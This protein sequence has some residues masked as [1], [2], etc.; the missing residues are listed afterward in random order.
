MYLQYICICIYLH[1]VFVSF[2]LCLSQLISSDERPDELTGRKQMCNL[3][4]IN[5]SICLMLSLSVW[6]THFAHSHCIVSRRFVKHSLSVVV[7]IENSLTALSQDKHALLNLSDFFFFSLP[8][9]WGRAEKISIILTTKQ[10]LI[11]S[12]LIPSLCAVQLLTPRK[13]AFNSLD[14][15][16]LDKITR[17]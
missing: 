10:Q 6:H 11:W 8:V 13:S 12:N 9:C 5:F 3:Q 16:L 4:P 1:C 15:S 14:S 17:S 7:M 2:A